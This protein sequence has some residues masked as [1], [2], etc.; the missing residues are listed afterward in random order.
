MT[1]LHD[2]NPG[3]HHSSHKVTLEA[4]AYGGDAVCHV[5]G[6]VVFVP[7]GVPGDGAFIELV[8][9]K[10]T[11]SRGTIHELLT[12]SPDR[13]NPFCP[14]AER[15]GGCQW[16]MVSYKSQLKWKRSIVEETIRRIGMLEDV[17]VEPCVAS[18]VECSYRTVVRY[19][20]R[21]TNRPI[22]FGYH[23]RRSHCMVDIAACPVATERVNTIA[24]NIRAILD[25]EPDRYD[26]S[27]ITISSSYNK[28]SSLISMTVDPGKQ[29]G[30]TVFRRISEID[31]VAGVIVRVA[32]NNRTTRRQFT[33]GN[34]HRFETIQG[35][36]FRIDERSFFQINIPQTIQ[37]VTI[38]R[39][40]L[41]GEQ[42]RKFVDGYGGVG[43]FSLCCAP[44][45]ANI[46]LF[47][48]S[49]HAV[50]DSKYNAD[51]RGLSR[52]SAFCDGAV[53]A[54]G[55]VGT[56]DVLILDPPRTGLGYQAVQAAVSTK[57]G[58][59]IY[60]SCN[61]TTLARDLALLL[62]HG[63]HIERIVPVDMFP[64][65]YHIETVTK[66]KSE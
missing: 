30:E 45:G 48:T 2:N 57:A 10:G 28:L 16:Q 11:Y 46:Y 54:L 24:S 49:R 8:A 19:P 55:T 21:T 42:C 51:V 34:C 6:Q 13:T 53:E 52:F 1:S 29:I 20:A 35:V 39:E 41:E 62:K 5:S 64:Q 66:L 7:D 32:G 58:S 12:A 22:V 40:M 23:E 56:T 36:S 47:D 37:L 3:T 63:Y 9:D 59:I 33:F 65:T 43:L 61:P 60:V 18:P 27:E 31:T 25:E 38:V 17:E 4:L 26:I 14:L 15:C 44:E 50:Q